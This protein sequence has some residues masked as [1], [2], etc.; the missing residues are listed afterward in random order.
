MSIKNSEKQRAAPLFFAE[1]NWPKA[2]ISAAKW[3]SLAVNFR[4]EQRKQRRGLQGRYAPRNMTR[5]STA[6]TP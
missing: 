2:R 5:A 4:E 3:A 6:F 1:P